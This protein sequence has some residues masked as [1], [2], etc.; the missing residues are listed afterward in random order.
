MIIQAIWYMLPAY[1]SNMAPVF[2]KDSFKFLSKP[3]NTKVF[4]SHKT[5]RGIFA[6]T[7][8]GILVAYLQH[9]M[10]NDYLW[11]GGISLI[12]YENWL[13][14]GFLM[15]FGAVFGDLIKSYFK[16]NVGI[17]PGGRWIP[18]DQ[19]D[20]IIGALVLSSFVYLPSLWMIVLIFIVSFL[21]HILINHVG[22]YLKIREVKW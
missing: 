1:F 15:G 8:F 12:N 6:G 21:G 16:R 22:Y 7:F 5:W 18:F 10:Y 2:F 17:K 13:L 19:L 3:V 14:F 4:G 20:Y 11:V 9:V